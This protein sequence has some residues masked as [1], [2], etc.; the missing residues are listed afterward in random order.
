V[1]R[2]PGLCP[3]GMAGNFPGLYPWALEKEVLSARATLR[4]RALLRV[5]GEF[6]VANTRAR[7][8]EAEVEVANT[9][10]R[11]LEG[12]VEVANSRAQRLEGEIIF[13]NRRARRLEGD[14]EALQE[15]SAEELRDL[16]A[17]TERGRA[18]RRLRHL[19]DAP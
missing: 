13:A 8:L 2:A 14:P 12:E 6:E 7:R 18:H 11:R 19:P 5:E 3:R 17:D 4:G 9:R 1:R 15:C 16:M 10:A